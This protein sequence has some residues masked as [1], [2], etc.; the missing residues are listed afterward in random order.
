MGAK[1]KTALIII[2][3]MAL[4]T[5]VWLFVYHPQG[6]TELVESIED[7]VLTSNVLLMREST[8]VSESNG[9]PGQGVSSG[10]SYGVGASG[11]IIKR[12]GDRYYVLT[13]YHVIKPK[14]DSVRTDILVLDYND[15][16][17]LDPAKFQESNGF[18]HYYDKF[19]KARVEFYDKNYDLAVISF[20]SNEDYATIQIAKSPPKFGHVVESLSNPYE[21]ARNQID[22][23]R[24]FGAY[25]TAPS[26]KFYKVQYPMITHTAKGSEG[27]SGGMVLNENLELVGVTLGGTEIKFIAFRF[28][29]FGKAMPANRVLEFLEE[30]EFVNE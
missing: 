28:Y 26:M 14:K 22:V 20:T 19:P 16:G 13:A 24:F 4:L 17:K 23:G 18:E 6:G 25:S 2:G 12:E 10:T 9:D 27:S 29:L 15:N 7:N 1:K 8:W 3:V 11:T 30:N 21:N 5:A